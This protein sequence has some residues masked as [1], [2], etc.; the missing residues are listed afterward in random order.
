MRKLRASKRI[1]KIS[2]ILRLVQRLVKM[3]KKFSY[4]LV[5]NLIKSLATMVLSQE[6]SKYPASKVKQELHLDHDILRN[7]DQFLV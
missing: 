6:A 4:M 1:M 7:L 3:W 2:N 5:N